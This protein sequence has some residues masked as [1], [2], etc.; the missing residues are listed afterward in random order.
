MTVN[1]RKVFEYLKAN[2]GKLMTAQEIAA[3]L[4]ISISAVTGSVNGLI[5]A[6]KHPA[7][8]ARTEATIDGPDG[9]K[10]KVNYISLTDEGL[11]FDPDAEVEG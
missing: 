2:H 8:A 4:E 3:D 6:T 1:S 7:Y 10:V 5:R 11:A 9:K